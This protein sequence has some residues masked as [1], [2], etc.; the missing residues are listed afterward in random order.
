[1]FY[2]ITAT[3][4]CNYSITYV[5][6]TWT[7]P[8]LAFVFSCVRPQ[9]ILTRNRFRNDFRLVPATPL[10]RLGAEATGHAARRPL[11][12]SRPMDP[13]NGPMGSGNAIHSVYR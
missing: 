7:R 8:F 5:Y 10:C 2:C 11:A 3:V 13:C 1:M 4:L 6:L 9:A 12:P